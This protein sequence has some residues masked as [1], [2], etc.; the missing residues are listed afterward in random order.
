MITHGAIIL[1]EGET[2]GDRDSA[3]H[4][5]AARLRLVPRRAGEKTDVLPAKYEYSRTGY[6]R[7]TVST[8]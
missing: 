3:T 6:Q 1:F 8:L 2:V 4:I 7:S 5:R